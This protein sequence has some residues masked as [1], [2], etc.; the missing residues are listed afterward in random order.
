[1]LLCRNVFCPRPRDA[2]DDAEAD[3]NHHGDAD[4]RVR[5]ACDRERPPDA[6]HENHKSDE[7]KREGHRTS[8]RVYC[9]TNASTG[10]TGTTGTTATTGSR[11]ELSLF[12]SSY[13]AR[14]RT[15][16][17]TL[18]LSYLSDLSCLS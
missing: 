6:G 2:G 4:V 16:V 5:D 8:S 18:D 10:S 15:P 1:M 3:E 11:N 13:R 17:P 14:R 9:K 12:I 7:V